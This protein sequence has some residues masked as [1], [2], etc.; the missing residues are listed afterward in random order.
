MALLSVGASP[1]IF[2]DFEMHEH[3]CY[4]IIM[5]TE[6][7]GIAE[8]G[9]KEYPF[10]PGTI[11]IIP[12]NTPHKKRAENGFRDM[13]LHTDSLRRKEASVRPLTGQSSSDPKE[14]ILLLDDACHT[15]EKILSVLLERY[16]MNTRTDDVTNALYEVLL[17]LIEEKCMDTLSDP[18][19]D[20]VI[21]NITVS[22]S[23]P[24]FHVTDALAATGYHID[25]IRR[26]F[27]KATGMTPNEYLKDVRIRYAKR[28][29]GQKEKMH[30]QISGIALRCGFYD[31]A[32]FCRTFRKEAGV[33][34]SEFSK[35]NQEP[36]SS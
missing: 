34:P 32:Y 23:D 27:Q 14:P 10:S 17:Q 12:P 24:E 36:H 3:D 26:R 6:G 30:L 22:Y 19:I 28:L 5:N 4:E 15:M 20:E 31:T 35:K 13:Y 7:E 1:A 16:L 18:L 29:L 11:H 2:K 25:H 21:H 8:I 9:E 33:S